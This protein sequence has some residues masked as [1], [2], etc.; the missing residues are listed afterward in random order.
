MDFGKKLDR[1]IITSSPD[2]YGRAAH[3]HEKII[4]DNSD[5]LSGKTLLEFGVC[6]G[7]SLNWLSNAYDAL[8]MSKKFYG[9]D[10]FKGLPKEEL[11][12]NNPSYWN[13]GSFKSPPSK[14]DEIRKRFPHTKLVKGLF[15]DTLT[16]ELADEIRENPLGYIHMDCDIYTSTIQV[17]EWIIQNDL[18]VDGTIVMY[19]DWGGHHDR[20]VGEFECGEGKA[21]KEI[22][23]KYGLNFEFISCNVIAAQGTMVWE[24]CG[25]KY[26]K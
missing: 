12:K 20:S 26:E 11:D 13:E 23:E 2:M 6:N 18:L 15:E 7:F 3:V 24:I 21:H 22:C 4:K 1:T 9:F 5:F 17:W 16:T 14:E 10:S 8:G 25:F 19:D